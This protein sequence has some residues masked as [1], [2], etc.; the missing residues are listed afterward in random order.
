MLPNIQW[1]NQKVKEKIKKYMQT[2]EN[3]ISM[4]HAPKGKFI[5]IKAYLKK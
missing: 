2:N 4:F 1:V 3:E 5:V